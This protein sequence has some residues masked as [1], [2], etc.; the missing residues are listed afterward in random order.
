MA[1]RARRCYERSRD[2]DDTVCFRWGV[3]VQ[4]R[5]AQLRRPARE[6]PC[7]TGPPPHLEASQG[8]WL[9]LLGEL[10]LALAPINDESVVI[11]I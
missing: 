11:A 7:G 4:N 1:I 10:F 9:L 8:R 3:E 5:I 6:S 2:E